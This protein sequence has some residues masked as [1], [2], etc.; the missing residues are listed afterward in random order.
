M[1]WDRV[2]ARGTGCIPI[3]TVTFGGLVGRDVTCD[4]TL[5][6]KNAFQ[7]DAY[8]PLFYRM[9]VSLTETRQRPPNPGQRPHSQTETPWTETPLPRWTE[10]QTGVK[11]STSRNFVCGRWQIESLFCSQKLP[12]WERD[13]SNRVSTLM[14]YWRSVLQNKCW[15]RQTTFCC[16]PQKDTFLTTND[17][18][19]TQTTGSIVRN[20]PTIH[21]HVNRLTCLKSLSEGKKIFRIWYQNEISPEPHCRNVRSCHII[22]YQTLSMKL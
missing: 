22:C 5:R 2:G 20:D 12:L 6:N 21:C 16:L 8:R 10:W 3:P 11:T 7:K 18:G 17:A 13:T 4:H 14:F 15:R 1:R 19:I 9:G